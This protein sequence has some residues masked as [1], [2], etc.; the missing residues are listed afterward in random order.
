MSFWDVL[1]ILPSSKPILSQY[2][3]TAESFGQSQGFTVYRT[4]LKLKSS[5]S[6]LQIPG[7]RD[8]ATIFLNQV[9]PLIFIDFLVVHAL[10]FVSFV[11]FALARTIHS[12]REC[13]SL[14]VSII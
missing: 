11:S 4:Q 5:S 2:P 12:K 1:K 10:K 7:V 13:C 3:V 8:R 14:I 6:I 9:R